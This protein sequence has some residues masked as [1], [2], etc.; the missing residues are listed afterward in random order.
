MST[1]TI[2]LA[3]HVSCG[4]DDPFQ[5]MLRSLTGGKRLEYRVQSEGIPGQNDACLHVKSPIYLLYT[6]RCSLT[7]SLAH[8]CYRAFETFINFHWF[9][10]HACSRRRRGRFLVYIHLSTL[11]GS[12][13]DITLREMRV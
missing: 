10:Q 13:G 12:F 5:T 2:W 1:S 11:N 9:K 7:S 4:E 3:V 6:Y 8:S